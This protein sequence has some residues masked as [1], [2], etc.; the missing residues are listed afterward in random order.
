M[1][2]CSNEGGPSSISWRKGRE[3]VDG[4]IILWLSHPIAQ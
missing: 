1:K 4:W 2:E 3:I